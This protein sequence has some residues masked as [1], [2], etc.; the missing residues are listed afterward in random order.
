M[1]LN[2]KNHYFN[3]LVGEIGKNLNDQEFIFKKPIL[4]CYCYAAND[5]LLL[6]L[7]DGDD[8]VEAAGR[9]VLASRNLRGHYRFTVVLREVVFHASRLNSK[10]MAISRTK[11]IKDQLGLN[12]T[13]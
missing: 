3:N 10:I 9:P 2:N 7:P 11:F 12:A 6:L 8:D 5:L 1:Y 13:L 4:C